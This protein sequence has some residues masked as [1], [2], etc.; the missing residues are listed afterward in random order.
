VVT[1]L[2]DKMKAGLDDQYDTIKLDMIR[3]KQEDLLSLELKTAEGMTHIQDKTD[4][5]VKRLNDERD[6]E[7]GTI[8]KQGDKVR[9]NLAE[10]GEM[11]QNELKTSSKAEKEK[12]YIDSK[13]SK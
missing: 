2:K 7:I 5:S 12:Q 1:E 4:A 9:T 11:L 10:L 6:K 3:R 8:H 13:Q